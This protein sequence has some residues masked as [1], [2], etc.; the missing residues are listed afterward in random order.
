M[1]VKNI[2]TGGCGYIYVSWIV[3]SGA[4]DDE[5]C[6]IDRFNVTL[7]S[8]DVSTT[9]IAQLPYYNFTGLPYDMLF[10]VTVGG[11]NSHMKDFISVAYSS[12]KTMAISESMYFV[13]IIDTY[14]CRTHLYISLWLNR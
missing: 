9:V 6:S 3:N 2:E 11:V 5:M 1:I 13:I 7:L 14:I 10:N 12:V 4:V 8:V